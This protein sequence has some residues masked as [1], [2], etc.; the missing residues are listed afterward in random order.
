[1][2]KEKTEFEEKFVSKTEKT[3][4]LWNCVLLL[5]LLLVSVY[6]IDTTCFSVRYC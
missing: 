3:K 1:M 5:L 4:K 2:G 6:Q